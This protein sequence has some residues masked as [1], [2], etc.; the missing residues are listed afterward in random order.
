MTRLTSWYTAK[1]IPWEYIDVQGRSDHAA[2]R[3]Y[4]IPTA[5]IFSGAET[6][7]TS[8][9]AQK[10]GGTGGRAFD[11]CYHSSCDTT[12]NI[13]ATS[14]DRGADLIG[15]MLWLYAAKDYGTTPPQPTGNLLL[16]PG[17][18]S[19]AVSLGRHRRPDHQQHGSSG[20][21]RDVEGVARR[22]WLHLDRVRPAV[23]L[24]PVDGEPRR[25]SRSGCAPTPPRAGAPP[26]TR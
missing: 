11:P 22:Q 14:L 1:G 18:E 25:R 13:N 9:Q 26:T 23:G 16:N 4:G 12:A 15:H 7:K 21:H 17:F 6:L 5:G 2:F 3:S 24:D 10:W 20:P 19:G 8:S